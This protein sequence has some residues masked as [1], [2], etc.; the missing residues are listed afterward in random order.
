MARILIVGVATALV[1]TACTDSSDPETEISIELS[2]KSPIAAE[3]AVSSPT[4]VSVTTEVVAE[5]HEA[6]VPDAAPATEH[7]LPLV[8]MRQNTDYDVT[9]TLTNEDGDEVASKTETLTTGEIPFELPP[10]E[11]SADAERA[12]PGVTL[13]EL[14]Q[15][16]GQ[17]NDLGTPLVAFDHDGEPVWFDQGELFVGA[18]TETEA[19][20]F[21]NQAF[22]FG[23]QEIDLL[24][25][26]VTSWKVGGTADG[27]TDSEDE[28][29]DAIHVTADWVELGPV[30]HDVREMPDGTLLAISL[31]THDLT[32]E[33]RESF[34]PDDP[35]EF[36]AQ[37]DVVVQFERDGTVLRT[38]DLWDVLD[39]DDNPGPLMCQQDGLIANELERDWT[40]ANSA[41]YDEERDVIIVSSRHTDQ[42]VAFD[43]LDDE[44]PQSSV[45]WILGE[46]GTIPITEGEPAFHTHSVS[47][48]PDGDLLAYDNG[49]T[50]PLSPGEQPYSRA[51]RFSVD[52]TG[53]DPSMWSATQVWEH[54]TQ[55][56]GGQDLFAPQLSDVDLLENGNVLVTH[57]AAATADGI[58]SRIVE[59]TGPDDDSPDEI[60]WDMALGGPGRDQFVYRSARLPS[61]YFGAAAT[62]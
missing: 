21:I 37:S 41:V 45:R 58:F 4:A 55:G 5:E 33:Q 2:D 17:S 39:V 62:P 46:D 34:C 29:G 25:S 26:I 10:I 56:P 12:S 16:D 35:N 14:N 44:G 3:L 27:T 19:G 9:V 13:V 8:G 30:H 6:I 32:D 42:I 11:F 31:T 23:V 18:V 51:V 47:V 24:G 43:H 28:P 7:A 1:A 36:S 53:D 15:F 61:L 48:L 52:D 50:R 22:P 59:V 57:G 40:H 60:V 49:N 54:R 38:W 20:T